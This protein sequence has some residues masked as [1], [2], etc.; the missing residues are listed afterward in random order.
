MS[1][2]CRDSLRSHDSHSDCFFTRRPSL[3]VPANFQVDEALGSIKTA[4]SI[5]PHEPYNF[6]EEGILHTSLKNLDEALASFNRVCIVANMSRH[7]R[8]RN[9]LTIT[10]WYISGVE[11]YLEW[12]EWIHKYNNHRKEFDKAVEDLTKAIELDP[13]TAKNY[14]E[15][16][17]AYAGTSYI[18]IN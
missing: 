8:L 11:L 2:D 12:G 1:R 16:S 17:I 6:L 9:A 18:N 15:R 10:Q 5:D 7:D 4:I 3:V 14:I 13:S